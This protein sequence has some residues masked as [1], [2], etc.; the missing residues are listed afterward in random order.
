MSP[1]LSLNVQ[2]DI[3]SDDASDATL[4]E[5]PYLVGEPLTRMVKF[6]YLETP[7]SENTD[8]NDF[9]GLGEYP[10]ETTPEYFIRD[11][12]INYITEDESPRLNNGEQETQDAQF[13]INNLEYVHSVIDHIAVYPPSFPSHKVALTLTI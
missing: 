7:S 10:D 11:E 12:E 8:F 1:T 13:G 2:N 4:D 6:E 3:A 9:E 5:S